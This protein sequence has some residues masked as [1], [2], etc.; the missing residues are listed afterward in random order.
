MI[1]YYDLVSSKKCSF[2]FSVQ[3]NNRCNVV[4]SILSLV[5]AMKKHALRFQKIINGRKP[6]I[7]LKLS[8]GLKLLGLK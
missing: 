3:F 5:F 6:K 4:I 1:L 7:H 2:N 8:R